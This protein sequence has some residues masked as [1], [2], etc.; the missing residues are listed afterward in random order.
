MRK[1]WASALNVSSYLR[2][3]R[4][5]DVTEVRAAGY[6]LWHL[7]RYGECATTLREYLDRAPEGAEDVPKVK[8]M[9]RVLRDMD[10]SSTADESE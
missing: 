5:A 2:A 7:Q 3:T 9:L 10:D 8:R 1:D 4:P 6:Y